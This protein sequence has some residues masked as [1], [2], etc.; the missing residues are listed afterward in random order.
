MIRL[1]INAVLV[2]AD[3][4]PLRGPH[5]ILARVADDLVLFKIDRP[6]GRPFVVPRA[7]V[8]QWVADQLVSIGP[9]PAPDY[10]RRTGNEIPT[11]HRTKR[12]SLWA[13][14]RPL[15]TGEDADLIFDEGHR[16]KVLT[17]RAVDVKVTAAYLYRVLQRYWQFG[18]IPN[19]LLPAYSNSG[20][21]GKVRASVEGSKRGRPRKVLSAGHDLGAVGVNLTPDDLKFIALSVKVF[22]LR[23][24]MTLK[25]SYDEMV[26]HHY[27]TRELFDGE[28]RKI[29]VPSN[30]LIQ[31]PAYRIGRLG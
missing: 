26:L 11:M 7:I 4:E 17:L 15:V 30:R 29:P 14:I 16:W 9:D 8:A 19:A 13:A 10:I 5:R 21:A 23:R 24:G 3:D 6:H 22:H 20:G 2:P 27:S 31:L 18:Q 1:K 28:V 25:E 12:D